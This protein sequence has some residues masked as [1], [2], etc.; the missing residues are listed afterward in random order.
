MD[1]GSG[2]TYR[3][4]SLF[5]C[6]HHVEPSTEYLVCS[7]FSF[8][9]IDMRDISCVTAARR[10]QAGTIKGSYPSF[11]TATDYFTQTLTNIAGAISIF[12]STTIEAFNLK[13][14]CHQ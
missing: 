3:T 6:A 10:L 14:R 7:R 12:V 9:I 4:Y 2:M 1:I 11:L 13:E 5:P 8:A